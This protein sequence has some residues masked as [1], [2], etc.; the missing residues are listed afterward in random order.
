MTAAYLLELAVPNCSVF[1]MIDHR[2]DSYPQLTRVDIQGIDL[3]IGVED[4]SQSLLVRDLIDTVESD[5]G[6]DD[7]AQVLIFQGDAVRVPL[8]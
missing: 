7:K 8:D 6:H 1:K 5:S 3:C 2:D 4:R